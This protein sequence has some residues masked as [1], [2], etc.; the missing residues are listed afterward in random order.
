M[1]RAETAMVLAAGP[2]PRMLSADTPLPLLEVQ[3]RS[4][5]DRVLDRLAE[6]GVQRVLVNAHRSPDQVAARTARREAPRVQV[7][8]E[9]S[10]LGSGGTV[11]AQLSALGPDPFFVV[12][13]DQIWLDGPTPSLRRLAAA[14]DAR[15]MDGILLLYRAAHA[16]DPAANRGEY[17][18]DPLGR[19]RLPKECEI[20]P[21]LYAGVMLASPA[22]FEDPAAAPFA[23]T[24]LWKRSIE[25]GRLYGL[26]HDGIWLQVVSQLDLAVADD[27]LRNAVY[28]LVKPGARVDPAG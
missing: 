8:D 23:L 5:L 10:L 16:H 12:N 9:P 20:V 3:G 24:T 11:A 14:F 19:I 17:A 6:A 22:L 1:T 7:V 26:V 25:A 15:T 13:A 27:M 21:Y 18:L 2:S 28:G 4:L